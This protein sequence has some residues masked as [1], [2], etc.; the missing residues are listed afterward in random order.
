MRRTN[1][2]RFA[3]NAEARQSNQICHRRCRS[4]L[5]TTLLVLRPSL[6]L[7][8][9]VALHA[10]HHSTPSMS[11]TSEH[12][13]RQL[14]VP[15][16]IIRMVQQRKTV[17]QIKRRQCSYRMTRMATG[18]IARMWRSMMTVWG[19]HSSARSQWQ[20]ASPAR[21]ARAAPYTLRSV[22]GRLDRETGTASCL[23]PASSQRAS[24]TGTHPNCCADSMDSLCC[25]LTGQRV[26][27]RFSC[28]LSSTDRPTGPFWRTPVHVD[29]ISARDSARRTASCCYLAL[30]HRRRTA[31]VFSWQFSGTQKLSFR[32]PSSGDSGFPI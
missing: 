21:C 13:D 16:A 31:N 27:P 15:I 19:A 28:R 3:A 10:P 24:T 8:A 25:S 14:V 12:A 1:G 6:Q 22:P 17:D 20:Q 9:R 29:S 26:A 18:D 2:R 11:R 5:A 30:V 23:A 32:M 4:D 7:P